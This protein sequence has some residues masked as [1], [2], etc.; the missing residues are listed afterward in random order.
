MSIGHIRAIK[1]AAKQP[2]T[3]KRYTIPKVSAKRKAQIEIDKQTFEQDKI[4]YKK[5]WDIN[6]HICINCNCS[7]GS[8]PKTFMFHHI[9]EKRN[10]PQFRYSP[11]NI[12][13][14]CLE[15]HSKCE[16]NIDYAPKIKEL[17]KEV[18][19]KLFNNFVKQVFPNIVLDK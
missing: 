11:I 16:T 17:R 2:K 10:F 8:Q 4:F 15:C 19:N 18:E 3:Q 7:L 14:L 6:K 1:E 5:I 9:L 13:L 12:A